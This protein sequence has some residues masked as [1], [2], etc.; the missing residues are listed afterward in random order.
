MKMKIEKKP[1]SRGRMTL[2]H[3]N[4]DTLAHILNLAGVKSYRTF[5][6]INKRFNVLFKSLGIP[7]ETFYGYLST[8]EVEDLYLKY[9]SHAGGY[10]QQKVM[11][12]KLESL[13]KGVAFG[14]VCN[15][16]NSLLEWSI[17]KEDGFLAAEICT[18]A[19]AHHNR[20]NLLKL[21]IE[22]LID[23]EWLSM[24]R[25]DPRLCQGAARA[26]NIQALKLLRKK[27]FHWNS[28][29]SASAAESGHLE[30][31]K[32]CLENG[33]PFSKLTCAHAGRCE[34][35]EILKWLRSSECDCEWDFLT[36]SHA[37]ETGNL[38]VLKWALENGCP[39]NYKVSENASLKGH[40]NVLEFLKEK[41][42][43]FSDFCCSYAALGG[44][45]KT[46][47]WLAKNNFKLIE[48]ITSEYASMSG[49][50]S[51]LHWLRARG[52][53]FNAKFVMRAA[54][55]GHIHLLNWLINNGCPCDESACSSA[56]R[57]GNLETLKFLRSR[58]CPWD[59]ST[60]IAA[61]ESGHDDVLAWLKSNRCPGTV[62]Q[63]FYSDF[64]IKI[65]LGLVVIN[66]FADGNFSF[67]SQAMISLVILFSLRIFSK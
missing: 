61:T 2:E 9:T 57:I 37:A 22:D 50:L 1:Q 32:W 45:L 64:L 16:S 54:S 44:H 24:L 8:S 30:I 15:H 60:F 29:T 10:I 19:A 65:I 23:E 38:P 5:G 6:L 33:C 7:K 27:N 20:L 28:L 35:L 31:L 53:S 43:E 63:S 66:Y 62:K 55:R 49:N 3:L 11:Q 13:L 14:V 56:A 47:Q 41:N 67:V 46:L 59:E 51:I 12:S 25:I 34:N 21:F 52:C 17:D 40:T 18:L 36:C 39:L 26:G 4:E 48:P 58:G 42:Y